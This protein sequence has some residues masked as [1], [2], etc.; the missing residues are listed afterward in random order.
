MNIG[1]LLCDHVGEKFSKEHGQYPDMFARLLHQVD[2]T[3]TF[4]I[5]EAQRGQ[6]PSDLDE[7]SAYLITGSRHGVNDGF[8]WIT[9]LENLILRLHSSQKKIIGI[10]FGHQ[11]IAKALGG[12]VVLASNGWGIGVSINQVTRKK[13]WMVPQQDALNLLVSHQEQVMELPLGAEILASSDF[14]PFYMLQ[15]NDNLLTVQGHPEFSKAY[16]QA[17]IEDRKSILGEA[18]SEEGLMSLQHKVDDYVFAHWIVN[19]LRS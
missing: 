2:P 7:A 10:C 15:I 4:S 18:L 12:K 13:S 3:L 8:P 16:S 5:Y 6:L 11:L 1:I 19:F 9:H 17:L 14:C